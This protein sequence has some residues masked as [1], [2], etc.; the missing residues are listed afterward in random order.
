MFVPTSPLTLPPQHATVLFSKR[1]HAWYSPATSCFTL[2]AVN[3]P[4]LKRV[5]V[6]PSPRLPKTLLPQHLTVLVKVNEHVN[7]DPRATSRTLPTVKFNGGEYREVFEPSP[8]FPL[9]LL[10]QHC[11]PAGTRPTAQTWRTPFATN[12]AFVIAVKE[13]NG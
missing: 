4:G 11:K 7:S 8:S 12:V 5:S 9:A 2:F 13:G 10:P 3:G 1:A 6:E